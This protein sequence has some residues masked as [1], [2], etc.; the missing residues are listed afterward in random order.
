[1]NNQSN[2]PAPQYHYTAVIA[3]IEH[4]RDGKVVESQKTQFFTQAL[5]PHFTHDRMQGLQQSAI[6]SLRDVGAELGEIQGVWVINL[7][8]LGYMTEAEF[9]APGMT[10]AP[11]FEAERH[12]TEVQPPA[13]RP[14]LSL[15]VD[16][17]KTE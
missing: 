10:M 4:T 16:N 15:A 3:E 11:D 12:N 2:P 8:R 14:G 17:T 1:M 9:F 7:L 5:S 6:K 13:T